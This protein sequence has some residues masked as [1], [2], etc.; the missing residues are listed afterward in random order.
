MTDQE[1]ESLLNL[2]DF[3]QNI[4]LIT[5]EN[6]VDYIDAVLLYC[7]KTGVEIETAAKIIKNNAKMKAKI[8]SVAEDLHYLPKSSKLDISTD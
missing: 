3:I 6:K 2:K 4:E 7:E 8:K 1:V 5:Q